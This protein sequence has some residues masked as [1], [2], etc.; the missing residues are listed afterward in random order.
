M[1]YNLR[2]RPKSFWSRYKGDSEKQQNTFDVDEWTEY[3]KQLFKGADTPTS[4]L[5]G[6]H[7]LLV[8]MIPKPDVLDDRKQKAAHLNGDIQPHEILQ[9]LHHVKNGKA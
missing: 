1:I 8:H 4:R 7:P 5:P 2:L 9:A 6:D 3:F